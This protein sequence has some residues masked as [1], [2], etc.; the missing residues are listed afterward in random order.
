MHQNGLV[1]LEGVPHRIVADPPGTVVVLKPHVVV[2]LGGE[3]PDL[4]L[5]VLRTTECVPR[6]DHPPEG[7]LNTEK[8]PLL[9]PLVV[10]ATTNF[11]E[12]WVQVGT[13]VARRR[14]P[15]LDVGRIL[16]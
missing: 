3:I 11:Q 4:R 9:I 5:G 2:I 6:I 1:L 12:T 10:T 13:F 7:R 8:F 14:T 15:S 16:W